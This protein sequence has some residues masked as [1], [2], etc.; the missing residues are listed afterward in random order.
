MSIKKKKNLL[1]GDCEAVS[2]N[3][4]RDESAYKNCYCISFGSVSNG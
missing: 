2:M 3:L 4:K 1:I